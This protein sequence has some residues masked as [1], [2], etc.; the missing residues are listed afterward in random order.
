MI[1]LATHDV[2]FQRAEAKRGIG[3][4]WIRVAG[5][6]F[7]LAGL[8]LRLFQLDAKSWLGKTR[9]TLCLFAFGIIF[10]L[11][12]LLGLLGAAVIG[13]TMT[14]MHLL[15]ALMIVGGA[16]LLAGGLLVF[17]AISRLRSSF[18][19]FER[20]RTEMANNLEWLRKHFSEG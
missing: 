13:L 8:Q 12:G 6:S 2:P 10:A 20:S 5:D 4:A 15:W 3:R 7:S 14:G 9:L 19:V 16:G 11:S 1:K 17:S 18:D